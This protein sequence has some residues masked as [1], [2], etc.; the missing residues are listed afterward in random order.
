MLRRAQVLPVYVVGLRVRVV[1]VSVNMAYGHGHGPIG[2]GR[3]IGTAAG[4]VID[5]WEISECV[6]LDGRQKL[7]VSRIL[8]NA[9]EDGFEVQVAAGG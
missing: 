1:V 8:V 4:C 9:I 6:P 7:P 5:R 3:R 2:S